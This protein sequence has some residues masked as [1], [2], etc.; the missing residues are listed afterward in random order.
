MDLKTTQTPAG[1]GTYVYVFRAE[2]AGAV[3]TTLN[4]ITT[5]VSIVLGVTSINNPTTYSV[6]GINEELDSELKI[7]RRKSVAISAKG[8][9]DAMTAMLENITGVTYAKVYEN[10]TD[11]QDSDSIPAHGMWAIVEGGTDAQIA[12]A[13]Y[14]KRSGGH[15]MKGSEQIHYHSRRWK[16]FHYFLG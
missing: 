11:T 2:N 10:T 16:P 15:A 12:A 14:A 7:R 9:N 6:L 5:P 8:Y 1:A 4:T 3:T 13:I